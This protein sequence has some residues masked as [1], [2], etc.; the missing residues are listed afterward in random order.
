MHET[1]GLALLVDE[2]L[3]D[4]F[5]GRVR[6]APLWTRLTG[7]THEEGYSEPAERAAAGQPPR[8][9]V[10]ELRVDQGHVDH[11]GG[12]MGAVDFGALTPTAAQR[13]LAVAALELLWDLHLRHTVF[14]D[15][16]LELGPRRQ[17]VLTIGPFTRST[18]AQTFLT[19]S[20]RDIDDGSFV[21]YFVRG[22]QGLHLHTQQFDN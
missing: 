21:L 11:V 10:G 1:E 8:G 22:E 18:S 7:F 17:G 9:W 6:L 3:W 20:W 13:E 12:L 2:L 15:A 19:A 16:P 5:P 14:G 4:E